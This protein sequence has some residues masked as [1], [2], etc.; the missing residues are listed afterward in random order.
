LAKWLRE[1]SCA[2]ILTF[3]RILLQ[4]IVYSLDAQPPPLFVNFDRTE[5]DTLRRIR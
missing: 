5:I 2:Y 3:D 1:T 4:I